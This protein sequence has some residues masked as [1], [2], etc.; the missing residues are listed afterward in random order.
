[1]SVS[2]VFEENRTLKAT[3]CERDARIAE[4]ERQ[5]ARLQELE[6]E[7]EALQ[8]ELRGAVRD[9]A[10]LEA[11]LRKLLAR[12]RALEAVLAPGQLALFEEPSTPTPPCAKEAPDGETSEDRIR[13]RHQRK[14]APRQ[15]AYA[16]L[17]R[18][19]VVHELPPEERVCSVTGEELIEVGE[20]TS[21]ELEYRPAKLV[22]IVH[23]RKV[24]GKDES[25][26][27]ERKV[28][29]LE[30][31]MPVRPIENGLVYSA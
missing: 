24:Y 29:P 2:D 22:V 11:R 25:A 30:A 5:V 18:E 6:R 9:R 17:P 1:V 14:N 15:V 4:L 31:R 8:R 13:P 21:E 12:R 26:R 7:I 10:R 23:H 27:S 20:K 3:L 16:A 19:H 28:K